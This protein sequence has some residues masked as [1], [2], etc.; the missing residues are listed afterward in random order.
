MGTL[1]DII[2]V[3]RLRFG[4]DA[5]FPSGEGKDWNRSIPARVV[6]FYQRELSPSRVGSTEYESF[7]LHAGALKGL[8]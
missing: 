2:P 8:F 3:A 7:L 5:M 6:G 4:N 1:R